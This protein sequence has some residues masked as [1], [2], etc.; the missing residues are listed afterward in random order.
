MIVHLG[1]CLNNLTKTLLQEEF[2]MENNRNFIIECGILEK[3]IGPGGDVTI[4]KG[5]TE[6]MCYTFADCTGLASVTIPDSVTEIGNGAFQDCTGLTSM[7]SRIASQKSGAE[8]S[9]TA[10]A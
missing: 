8:S 3:Y 1:N 4:P 7:P 5:V 2:I 9:R 6:I 10:Q